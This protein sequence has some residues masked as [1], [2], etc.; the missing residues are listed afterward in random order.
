[1]I[2]SEEEIDVE[3]SMLLEERAQVENRGVETPTATEQEGYQETSD[4]TV[5]V[6]KRVNGLELVVNERKPHE[7]R[8]GIRPIASQVA[9]EII[10]CL[11]HIRNRGRYEPRVLDLRTETATDPVLAVSELPRP[12]S[13]TADSLH[14]GLVDLSNQPQANGKVVQ[15]IETMAHSVDVVQNLLCIVI[16]AAWC[17]SSSRF[18]LD[19]DELLRSGNGAFDATR[20]NGFS[21]EER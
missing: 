2:H 3:L 10:Q 6:P 8:V 13:P 1:L 16:E 5:A 21:M 17:W 19:Q 11:G 20:E 4:A 15:P 9:L 14:Q 18:R 12:L 7:E